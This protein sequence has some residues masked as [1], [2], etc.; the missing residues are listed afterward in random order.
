MNTFE[1]STNVKSVFKCFV[2][3][4]PD[5]IAGSTEMHVGELLLL[6]VIKDLDNQKKV[7]EHINS[8]IEVGVGCLKLRTILSRAFYKIP[9]LVLQIHH[10]LG[11]HLLLD[12]L[13]YLISYFQ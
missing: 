12:E 2:V 1:W 4:L 3:L 5:D 7:I 8:A 11:S 10:N 9:K 6:I 13:I